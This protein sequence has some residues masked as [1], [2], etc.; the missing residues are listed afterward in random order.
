MQCPVVFHAWVV[1]AG[2]P[3]SLEL[4]WLPR[5]EKSQI[6]RLF[7]ENN[8]IFKSSNSSAVTYPDSRDIHTQAIWIAS[9]TDF[10][11]MVKSILDCRGTQTTCQQLWWPIPLKGNMLEPLAH[12]VFWWLVLNVL[13]EKMWTLSHCILLK[14]IFLMTCMLKDNFFFFYRKIMCFFFLWTSHENLYNSLLLH[15]FKCLEYEA[16]ILFLS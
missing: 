1:R 14:Y 6:L 11:K 16:Y 5:Q 3:L 15:F 9:T 10:D 13:D 4:K 2:W 7:R 8:G 12:S